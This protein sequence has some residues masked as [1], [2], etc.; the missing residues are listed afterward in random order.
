ML[1]E[2][3]LARHTPSVPSVCTLGV[4]DGV[5]LG[6]QALVET[7]K[8]K[9]LS[10]GWASAAVVLHPHPRTVL[11]PGINIPL[12]TSVEERVYLLRA[13]GLQV[14]APITFTHELSLLTAREFVGLLSRYLHMACLMVGPDF[15]LGHNREGTIPVLE[16]LGQEFGYTVEVVSLLLNGARP[17]S[18]TAIREAIAQGAVETAAQQLGRPYVTKGTVVQG[19]ARGR[20]L[21]YPTANLTPD[22][23]WALP[24][25]GI[26]A[27]RVHVADTVYPAAAYIGSKPTFRGVERG[28]EVFLLDFE[29]DLYGRELGLEWVRKLRDDQQFTSASA[30][31]GQM[32][33]DIAQARVV[34]SQA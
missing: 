8:T 30:L 20:L 26:Y 17:V 3:E 14:V 27:S 16:A 9:A 7:V 32:A 23:L 18:S 12:L 25:D 33:E 28:I 1:V 15:A 13:W 2:E 34:L 19:E 6:H 22:P 11:S 29:G 24:N 21:G 5:H 31:Q 10:Q 4:F